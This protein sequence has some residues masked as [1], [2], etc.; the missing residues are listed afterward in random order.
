MFVW[1]FDWMFVSNF[2]LDFHL[3]FRLNFQLNL[4]FELSLEFSIEL[5]FDVS[6]EFSLRILVWIFNWFFV[7]VFDWIF[8]SNFRLSVL[9]PFPQPP[10]KLCLSYRYLMVLSN[11]LQQNLT[12][13]KH[14]L[15]L[16]V[17]TVFI[18]LKTYTCPNL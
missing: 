2:S 4:R 15:T 10:I 17:S 8:V 13:S 1:T 6:I 3:I 9:P 14:S 11:V 16:A 5:A 18:C 7:W 12:W